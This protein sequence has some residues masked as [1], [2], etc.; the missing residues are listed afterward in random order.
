MKVTP[1]I[2]LAGVLSFS[3]AV[4]ADEDEIPSFKKADANKD[5]FV[6]E[7]E[8]GKAKAAGVKKTLAELDKDK[9]GKLS[10]EEYSV[11]LEE[12]CE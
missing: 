9:D 2:I 1:F 12:D 11:I 10:K 7:K 6:D 8:F 5:K 4:M 3:T